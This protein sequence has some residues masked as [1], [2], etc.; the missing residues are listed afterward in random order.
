[1]ESQEIMS[2]PQCDDGT[3]P[4]DWP[5]L[6]WT[7]MIHDAAI[8]AERPVRIANK[9]KRW[10]EEVG[11]VDVEERVF[12][13]PMNGW[14]RD[15]H[16]KRLGK[17]SEENWHAGLS[18]FTMGLFSRILNWSKT[19]IEVFLV[20]IR[21]CLSDKKVHA[22]HKIYVVWGRKPLEGEETSPPTPQE[23]GKTPESS[24]V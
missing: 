6:E 5:F 3:M 12:K 22:Y 4:A 13:M 15:G 14:P 23:D 20:H 18:A 16:L 2:S 11:F 17:M 24:T 7:K 1:M 10:Y 19:E 9:L 8:R 21:K